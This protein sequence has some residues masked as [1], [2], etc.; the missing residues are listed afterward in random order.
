MME[1][2]RSF[3]RTATAGALL[4]ALG[5]LAAPARAGGHHFHRQPVGTVY[6][7]VPSS[8]VVQAA[9]V[10]GTVFQA[11][12]AQPVMMQAPATMY[13]YPVQGTVATTPQGASAQGPLQ[14]SGSSG[15][16]GELVKLQSEYQLLTSHLNGNVMAVH[17]LREHLR[18]KL[19]EFKASQG[20]RLPA[21]DAILNFL[22]NAAQDYL[23]T[24][25]FGGVFGLV[26]PLIRDLIDNLIREDRASPA[27]VPVTPAEPPESEPSESEPSATDDENWYYFEGYIK[28]VPRGPKPNNRDTTPPDSTPV[29]PSRDDVPE[30]SPANEQPADAPE[31]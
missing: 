20:N 29:T 28:R 18:N 11:A 6:Y 4:A 24:I 23:S 9:P 19:A 10:A 12:P 7:V 13:Y 30:Q 1:S 16:S 25:G 2:S 17:G 27:P 5:G 3:R 21:R 31:P 8:P 15:L 22:L 26:K 14:S